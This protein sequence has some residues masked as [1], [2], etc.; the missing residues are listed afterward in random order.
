MLPLGIV[1]SPLAAHSQSSA[2][3]AVQ[4][5][6]EPQAGGQIPLRF[7]VASIRAHQFNGDEP[8]DRKMLPGG[9]FVATATPLSTLLRIAFGTNSISGA[10]NWVNSETF[11]IN[12]TTVNHADVTTPQQF[13][14]LILSLLEERFALKFH[15]EEKEVP[16]YWLELDN[17]EKPGPGLR[18]SAPDS[19]PNISSNSDGARTEMRATKMTMRDV[20]AAL[21]RS[22]GRLVEDHTGLKGNFDFQIEWAPEETPDSAIPSLFTV[23]KE[24][25]GLRLRSAKGT[26]QTVIVDGISHPTDN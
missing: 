6:N 21:S 4:S 23:L 25:L 19:E 9:R 5:Q 14:Q 16:V 15:R 10:P 20:A 11:D 17:P 18:T 3:P 22:A 1:W 2:R 12:G 7:E 8:S 26:A 13:Q 24:Q